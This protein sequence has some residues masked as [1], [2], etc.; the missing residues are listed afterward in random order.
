MV[1]RLYYKNNGMQIE[2]ANT[3]Q[4]EKTCLIRRFT[5]HSD[6][7]SNAQIQSLSEDLLHL[8]IL[9]LGCTNDNITLS[10]PSV[11]KS[12]LIA[13]G[14]VVLIIVM[15]NNNYKSLKQYKKR[16]LN[17]QFNYKSHSTLN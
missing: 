15:T 14:S 6:L 4:P 3:M 5:N 2:P 10:I 7:S 12:P 17:A 16:M 13:D 9:N 11:P 1:S 8:I